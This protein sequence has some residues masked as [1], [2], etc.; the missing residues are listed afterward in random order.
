MPDHER[1]VGMDEMKRQ[2]ADIHRILTGNGE[3]KK[4][5]VFKMAVVEDHVR[6]MKRFGWLILTVS[7]GLPF[8]VLTHIILS[9][10]H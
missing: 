4:G 2:I 6:F 5:L 1:R 8:T 3:P 10:L 7:I 9:R